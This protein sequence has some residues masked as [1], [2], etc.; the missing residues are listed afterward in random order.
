MSTGKIIK[1]VAGDAL[2]HAFK[3][4]A[5]SDA[6]TR[7]HM[8]EIAKS[9]EPNGIIKFKRG[10]EWE[11]RNG[12]I[13]FHVGSGLPNKPATFAPEFIN[14]QATGNQQEIFRKLLHVGDIDVEIDDGDGD[15]WP[16]FGTRRELE[17]DPICYNVAPKRAPH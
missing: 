1:H 17:L 9:F 8:D 10:D 2:A 14:D 16:Y 7:S 15:G 11:I 12:C 5:K 13:F 3:G 4:L 6:E